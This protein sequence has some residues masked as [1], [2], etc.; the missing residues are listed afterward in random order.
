MMFSKAT[1]ATVVR[2][3]AY[4]TNV[5]TIKPTLAVQ[6]KNTYIIYLSTVCSASHQ[7]A[8]VPPNHATQTPNHSR[9]SGRVALSMNSVVV[10]VVVCVLVVVPATDALVVLLLLLL[11]VV[12]VLPV[13]VSFLHSQLDATAG[14][15]EPP[16]PSA[17]SGQGSKAAAGA[18]V[19][20][21]SA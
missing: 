17:T 7:A 9:L 12:V 6:K 8:Q 14:M 21:R 3:S 16:A 4:G 19:T 15:L 20:T 1:T 18:A 11:V 2:T 10:V 5:P 13:V